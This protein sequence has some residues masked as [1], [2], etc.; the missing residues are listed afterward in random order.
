VEEPFSP[1]AILPLGSDNRTRVMLFA[2]NLSLLP[3]ETIADVAASAE[4]VNHIQYPLTVEYLGDVAGASGVTA[5]VFR[6]HDDLGDVGDIL[7]GI[8]FRGATS[9]RVRVG[10]GHIGGFLLTTRGMKMFR[11]RLS[12]LIPV[13]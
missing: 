1:D 3:T 6:L 10:I 9:N 11:K 8:T 5:I 13:T 2:N 12:I 4:D 7:V